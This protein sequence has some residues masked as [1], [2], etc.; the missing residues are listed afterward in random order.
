[1]IV[2]KQVASNQSDSDS[3]HDESQEPLLYVDV[4]L[5]ATKTRIALYEHSQPEKVARRFVREHGLDSNILENLTNLLREQLA[6]ALA[7]ID[8]VEEHSDD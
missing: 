4:N 5:G 7:N 6:N 1:V 2:R 8:E 3:Q